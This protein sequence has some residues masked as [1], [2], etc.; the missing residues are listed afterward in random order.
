MIT[1]IMINTVVPVMYTYGYY[2]NKI[3]Y[4]TKAVQW[5][6]ELNA[7]KNNITSKFRLLG[8]TNS[9]A[10]DSQALLHLKNFYCNKKRCLQCAVGN[11][12][13]ADPP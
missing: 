1:N 4:Q 9:S 7:E 10:Y 6:E 12:I 3:N 5:M 8:I 2:N 13:L 11:K